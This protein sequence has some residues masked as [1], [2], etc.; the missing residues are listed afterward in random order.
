MSVHLSVGHSRGS[1]SHPWV[2]HVFVVVRLRNPPMGQPWSSNG[3]LWGVHGS[4]M[5]RPWVIYDSAGLWIDHE[6]PKLSPL[7]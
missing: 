3:G 2:I 5:G 7:V 6:L 4:P 1:G